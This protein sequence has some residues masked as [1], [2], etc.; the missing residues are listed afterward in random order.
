MAEGLGIG[1]LTLDGRKTPP[2]KDYITTHA[3]EGSGLKGR[4][5]EELRAKLNR[6]LE[7]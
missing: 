5:A 3:L 2:P 1:Q 6:L 7:G 4:E